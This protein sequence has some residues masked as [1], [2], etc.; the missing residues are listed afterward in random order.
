MINK[1]GWSGVTAVFFFFQGEGGIRDLVRLRGIGDVLKGQAKE[2]GGE[3][4][5]DES[6]AA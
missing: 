6:A 5:T 3:K 4:K 2:G 1:R